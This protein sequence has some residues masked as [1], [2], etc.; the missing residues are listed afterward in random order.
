VAANLGTAYELSGNLAEAHDWIGEGIRRNKEAH[1]GTEWLH[2]RILEARQALLRD[3]D[4]LN[5]NSVTGLN[6][7]DEAQP[8]MPEQWPAGSWGADAFIKAL[9][10]QLRER[11]AFV[12]APDPLVGSLI[13]EL[14]TLLML[15][16]G[17]SLAIPVFDLALSYRP[18]NAAQVEARKSR[19]E[20]ILQ[21]GIDEDRNIKLALM[22]LAT[23][24]IGGAAVLRLRQGR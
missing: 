19:S 12:P 9:V 5:T 16:R 13:A 21:H 15:Y 8:R 11:M 10:Y 4:W 17:V 18:V 22:G 23:L 2:L 1:D 20:E 14:G 3:P 7:G 6:F 24:A